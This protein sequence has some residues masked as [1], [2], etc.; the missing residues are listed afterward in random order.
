MIRGATFVL[1]IMKHREHG[2]LQS[3]LVIVCPDR[4]LEPP[5]CF[6]VS[7]CGWSLIL[8]CCLVNCL[9]SSGGY[10]TDPSLRRQRNSGR[11]TKRR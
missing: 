7:P 4:T 10:E 9:I 3:T 8:L 1:S 11:S 5:R 2:N 6:P